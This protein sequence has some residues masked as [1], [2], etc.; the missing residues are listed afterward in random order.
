[1]ITVTYSG[2]N[3]CLI[4][5]AGEI[6][7]EIKL[8]PVREWDTRNNGWIIPV[9]DLPK[10]ISKTKNMDVKLYSDKRV[11]Q[12]YKELE[13]TVTKSLRIKKQNPTI[14]N[15]SKIKDYGLIDI[16]MYPYQYI[17]SEFIY[18]IE[19]C[20][21][22]DKVGLG[23]TIQSIAVS[24]LRLNESDI[25]SVLIVCPSSVKRNWY[26]E[27]TKHTD[28]IAIIIDGTPAKRKKQ[29]DE[30]ADYYIINYE[31][32]K[33]DIDWYKKRKRIYINGWEFIENK[34][35]YFIMDEIQY[36]R[37]GKALRT[38]MA[39]WISKKAK[40]RLGLSA[41]P[42]EKNML[43][44]FNIFHSIDVSVL[45]SEQS[46]KHFQDQFLLMDWFNN[47]II[48]YHGEMEKA[49][50]S[51][52]RWKAKFEKDKYDMN[53]NKKMRN[54]EFR[55]E[56]ISG[57]IKNVKKLKKRIEPYFIR[58]NKEDV[59]DQLPD[60]VEN[61][62]WIELSSVQ[63]KLY[64][65]VKNQVVD[66]ISDMNK[67]EKIQ[68]A[69]VLPLITYLRQC[70][71]SSKLV[72]TDDNVSTKLDEFMNFMDSINGEKVVVFCF[73]TDMVDLISEEL[74]KAKIKHI[75]MHGKNCKAK[76]RQPLINDF[77]NL[78]DIR[79]LVTSDILREGINLTSAKYLV[80]F[81]IL[82]NPF[83]IEQRIGRIDR[84]GQ[85]NDSINIIN[86]IA[87]DTIEERIFKLMSDKKNLSD[88]LFDDKIESRI[89]IQDIENL[90]N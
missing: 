21:L 61:N 30:Y 73:F 74:E 8:L 32:L 71:L 37:N 58:R 89:T 53:S 52:E 18:N 67:A 41:T 44:V 24:N 60:R 54:A 31:L 69:Q 88:N 4:K 26:D 46:Y 80:N 23:K 42:M 72:G 6:A 81:D 39:K 2:D 47:V 12:V 20:L 75:S 64:N 45:G 66:M 14:I 5:N 49:I 78:D 90:L 86:F 76:D 50:K 17:G 57:K 51:Y 34:N 40:Y 68:T 55:I 28:K 33:E 85:K 16:K 38:K 19:N 83:K 36:V 62:Y 79:V 43:D 3:K 65:N 1:M 59:L 25:D 22:L 84:I 10:L 13:C 77:N 15:Q 82:W 48:D 27:I 35:F 63:R 70:V 29:Y 87:V 56:D 9:L 11:K 7:D